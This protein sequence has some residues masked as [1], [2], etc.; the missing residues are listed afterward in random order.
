M[1]PSVIGEGN[2]DQG[3]LGM[4]RFVL[5]ENI[6]R[7]RALMTLAHSEQ[8]RETLR[9]LLKEAELELEE[10]E[11]ASTPQLA[12]RDAWLNSLARRAIDEAMTLEGAQFASLQV[13]DESREELIILAQRNLRA[14]FLHHLAH[15]RPG[16]GSACGRCLADDAAAAIGDVNGDVAF[17]PHLEAAREAGFQ[18]VRAFPVRDPSGQLMAVL[19]TY[20]EAPREFDDRDLDRMADITDALGRYLARHQAPLSALGG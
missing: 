11:A 15:M 18:A 19:S 7:F 12:R 16:D 10:L 17:A 14:Q 1:Q 5:R 3:S 2:L 9:Q 4:W 8:E 20:F 6:D 13:F